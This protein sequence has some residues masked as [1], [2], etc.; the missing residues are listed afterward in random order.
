MAYINQYKVTVP[1]TFTLVCTLSGG[2]C[3]EVGDS[4]ENRWIAGVQMFFVF[5]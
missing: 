5:F 2:F 4:Q 1:S 3:Q